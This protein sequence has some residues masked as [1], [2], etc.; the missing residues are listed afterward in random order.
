[1]GLTQ[2]SIFKKWLSRHSGK[3][4]ATMNTDQILQEIDLEIQRLRE[5]KALLVGAPARKTVAKP[6]TKPGR[7]TISAAGR[8]RIAAAQKARW[9]KTKRA[10]K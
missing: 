7:R 2:R 1:M 9:A 3:Y 4:N 10:G 5:V 6:S 8:A